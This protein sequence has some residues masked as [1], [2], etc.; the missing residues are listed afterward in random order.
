VRDFDIEASVTLWPQGNKDMKRTQKLVFEVRV[1]ESSE[2]TGW[3]P[4]VP[5]EPEQDTTGT[6]EP[7]P[8]PVPK[9]SPTPVSGDE[10][11][12]QGL[13]LQVMI[14][15][16]LGAVILLFLVIALIFAV[17]RGSLFGS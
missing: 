1:K 2:L 9:P 5:R 6:P 11:D 17:F 4:E 16:F 10:E 14:L 8:T 15:I 13:T 3:P 12:D 7:S